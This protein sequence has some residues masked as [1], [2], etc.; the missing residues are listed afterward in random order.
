MCG[1]TLESTSKQDEDDVEVAHK[2]L[3]DLM[4]RHGRR[5]QPNIELP[6]KVNFVTE[7]EP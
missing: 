1:S 6:L 7:S 5:S 4:D 2:E 3:I